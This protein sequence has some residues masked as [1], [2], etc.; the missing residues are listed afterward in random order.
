MAE[1]IEAV[2]MDEGVTAKASKKHAWSPEEDALLSHTVVTQGDTKQ[3]TKVAEHLPGRSGRQC[4][5]RWFMQLCPGVKHGE[6]VGGACESSGV[7]GV[8]ES[9]DC[10]SDTCLLCCFCP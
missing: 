7:S 9:S 8:S 5:E 10:E 2:E 6:W 4:R 3:W 1:P